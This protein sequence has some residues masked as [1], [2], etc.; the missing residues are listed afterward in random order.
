MLESAGMNSDTTNAGCTRAAARSPPVI[1]LLLGVLLARALFAA[2]DEEFLGKSRGYPIGTRGNWYF[3]ETVRVG[4]FSNLDKLLPHHTLKK[5]A[6][7]SP[8]KRA[9]SEPAFT[10]RFNNQTYNID[11][12]LAH[13]RA[14]GLLVSKDG[15]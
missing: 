2:P 14:T 1:A 13:Q 15:E 6:T 8:L 3:D 4:A 7:P 11:D 12:Y 5:A 10:Y 9:A